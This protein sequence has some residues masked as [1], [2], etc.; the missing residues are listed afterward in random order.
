MLVLKDHSKP[1]LVVVYLEFYF[2]NSMAIKTVV[3]EENVIIGLVKLVTLD[4]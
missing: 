2:I 3:K 4:V 1:K